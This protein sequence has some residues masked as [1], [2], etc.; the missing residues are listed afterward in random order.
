HKSKQKFSISYGFYVSN[1]EVKIPKV[2]RVKLK[3]KGYIPTNDIKIN[4]MTVSKEADRWF[5]SVQCEQDI[6]ESKEPET[7][8]GVD[9]GIKE[10]AVCSNGQIFKN[11]K[12]LKKS[13]KKLAHAQKNLAR[14]KFDKETKKSSNN[15]N[16]AKLKVQKI[17][18]KIRNQRSD[19]IHKMTSNLVKTKP[20]YIVLEDLNVSGM[21]KNHKLAGAVADA[22]FY[23]IKRQLQYKTSW[24]GGKVIEVDRFFPSSKLCSSCGCLKED[25]TLQD[26]IYICDCGLSIDRDL[27]ASINLEHYGLDKLKN[28]VS[29][30]GIKA[31]GE[32]VIPKQGICL[33][34][35][36]STKQEENMSL[37]KIL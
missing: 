23:E 26:R 4:S 19:T 22:S 18:R 1:T 27:N 6:T 2:G 34:E 9:V 33:T 8:L 10:L 25:L 11:P 32:S 14:K 17:F 30:T 16:K 3:E 36:V 12:Y 13:K 21:M 7:V 29:S 5:I 15:R 31:C 20:R 28:T 35:A 37:A 24:Y